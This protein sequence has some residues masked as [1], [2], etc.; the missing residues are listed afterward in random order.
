MTLL[1]SERAEHVI[2]CYYVVVRLLWLFQRLYFSVE[3]LLRYVNEMSYLKGF[4]I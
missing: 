1:P 3:L 4:F 2:T